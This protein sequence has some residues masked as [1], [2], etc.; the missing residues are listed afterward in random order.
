MPKNISDYRKSIDEIDGKIIDLLK[1]RLKIVEQVGEYK[2][3]NEVDK[4]PIFLRPGRE[5]DMLRSLINTAKDTYSPAV[6]ANIWRNI[7]SF[8]LNTEQEMGISV[9]NE[10]D[11]WLSREYFG[12]FSKIT[13]HE[14]SEEAI[15]A[16][17]ENSSQIVVFSIDNDKWWLNLPPDIKI[18]ARIP[19]VEGEDKRHA[20]AA[21]KVAPEKTSDN[22]SL[23]LVKNTEKIKDYSVLD[24]YGD[25]MLVSVKGFYEN[26]LG[27]YATPIKKNA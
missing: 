12:S 21:A 2:Q 14:T 6:I 7:I 3:L 16:V 26:S 20:F 25:N 9:Y 15:K 10:Q 18:F 5:A 8:S 24:T 13:K 23:L 4:S 17:S 1:K 27:V 11:Y 22:T 19:F